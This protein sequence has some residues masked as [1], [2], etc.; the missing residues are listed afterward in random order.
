MAWASSLYVDDVRLE[1][2][3]PARLPEAIFVDGFESGD[4]DFWTDT[5]P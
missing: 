5:E 4:L 3:V 2:C 1:V